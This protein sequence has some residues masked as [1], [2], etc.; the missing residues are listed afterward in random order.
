M[1]F[2]K[3][4]LPLCRREARKQD[5]REAILA[6]ACRAFVENGY[7]ATTMSAIAAKVGGSKGTLWSYF[8]SKEEL[9]TEVIEQMTTEFRRGLTSLLQP[10]DDLREVVHQF[11]LRFIEKVTSAQSLALYR[12]IAAESGRSPELGEV[13][14]RRAPVATQALMADFLGGHM[15]EGHLRK[16]DPLLAAQTLTSLCL[17]SLH[18]RTLFAQGDATPDDIA[19]AAA[20]T[21][22]IFMRAF[23]VETQ[24]EA[25]SA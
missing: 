23:A 11:C 19:R 2:I 1:R 15:E 10:S 20:A 12:L 22:D 8:S 17:G 21:T 25:A 18:Q 3:E 9:F 6:I 24:G 16:A 13:F 5:R 14:Y 4:R 7:A